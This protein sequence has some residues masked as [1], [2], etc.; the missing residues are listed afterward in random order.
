MDAPFVVIANRQIPCLDLGE[1]R[2]VLCNYPG[3]QV[4]QRIAG[5]RD[6]GQI[7]YRPVRV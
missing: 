6:T 4:Y 3:A 2:N 5:S 1:V 7:L